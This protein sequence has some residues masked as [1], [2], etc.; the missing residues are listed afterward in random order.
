[1][2]I[3]KTKQLLRF[4]KFKKLYEKY[5]HLL[6]PGMLVLG[7]I[8]DFITFKSIEIQTTF[9]ILSIHLILSGLAMTYINFYDGKKIPHSINPLRYIRLACPLIVQFTFGGLLSASFIFY[10]FS[11]A[12]AITWPFIIL[13][14]LLMISN[15]TFRDYYLKPVVQISVYYFILFAILGLMLPYHFHSISSWVFI[16]SGGISL[17]LIFF[18]LWILS[19]YLDKISAQLSKICISILG[20]FVTM[21]LFYSL[22]II[23]PIPLAL[24]DTGVFH[25]L[26]RSGNVY[27]VEAEK[28][29]ILERIIP[30]Q[31]IHVRNGESIYV[32]SAI[33]APSQLNTR[34]V[35]HWQYY[36]KDQ[37]KWITRD[38]PSFPLTGGRQAGYR[39]Y[40]LS[41]NL[42]E[43][44]WRVD[45]ETERG[46]V[47][48]RIKFTVSEVQ[49]SPELETIF[50]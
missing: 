1:M 43:G 3:E 40:S 26:Q 31:T 4:H 42:T 11:G 22:N 12:L 10:W 5:E 34:I 23:P 50:K 45:V 14:V 35:H 16:L 2:I 19:K 6:I 7:I 24:R 15:D 29:S 49:E 27:R 32:Y 28:R 17:A 8:I 30:G 37:H 25:S 36:N 39:G 48:G 21:L 47:I 44:K 38:K 13:L 46:Q 9:I 20:I 41:S 33:F 18:Y